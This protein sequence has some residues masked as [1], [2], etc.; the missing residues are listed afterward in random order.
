MSPRI[1]PRTAKQREQAKRY[2]KA[3]GPIV[4]SD[5]GACKDSWWIGVTS[6]EAFA[7]RVAEQRARM[8]LSKFG[9]MA[10]AE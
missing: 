8:G 1:G 4:P 6:R 9:R 5:A 3:M 2:G 7:A 10:T